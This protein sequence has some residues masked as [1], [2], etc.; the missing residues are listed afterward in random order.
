MQAFP[1]L[2]SVINKKPPEDFSLEGVRGHVGRRG[3]NDGG[4]VISFMRRDFGRGPR[5]LGNVCVQLSLPVTQPSLLDK[6]GERALA[7]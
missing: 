6:D 5:L 1:G 7:I 4:Q 2:S 3:G